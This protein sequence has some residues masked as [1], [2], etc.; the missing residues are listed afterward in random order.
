MPTRTKKTSRR[1][2]ARVADPRV[3]RLEAS[4]KACSAEVEKLQVT[5]TGL[6]AE[7]DHLREMIRS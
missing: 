7:I 6:K 1:R 2:A 4:V 3:K 5:V